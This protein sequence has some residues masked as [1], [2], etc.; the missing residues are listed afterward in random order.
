MLVCLHAGKASKQVSHLV[1]SVQVP[2]RREDPRRTEGS[3]PS[4]PQDIPAARGA[5]R[6]P[7]T[8]QHS[9]SLD[10]EGDRAMAEAMSRSPGN[11]SPGM[12]GTA[13][14]QYTYDY[15][16]LLVL[17]Y[18]SSAGRQHRHLTDQCSLAVSLCF[19]VQ[20][21]LDS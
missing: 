15:C 2:D 12:L 9:G 3:R 13:S 5:P 7:D 21:A 17:S 19:G 20:C 14:S 1:Y 4:D 10:T 8:Q 18:N 11:L 6:P 16:R